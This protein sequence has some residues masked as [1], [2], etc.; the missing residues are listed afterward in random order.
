LLSYI[1]W[2]KKYDAD[3]SAAMARE[4]L[5]TVSLLGKDIDTGRPSSYAGLR[6]KSVLRWSKIIVYQIS[7]DR[8]HI[9]TILDTRMDRPVTMEDG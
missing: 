9:V 6:E 1:G 7:N 3:V 4:L 8:V 2:Y 5:Q